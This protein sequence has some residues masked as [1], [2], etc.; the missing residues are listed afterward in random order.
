MEYQ[1]LERSV[2]TGEPNLLKIKGKQSQCTLYC[3]QQ[4]LACD[5]GNNLS[6]DG[7]N[8][9]CEVEQGYSCIKNGIEKTICTRIY[10]FS[11]QQAMSPICG[12]GII[13]RGEECD[14]QNLNS[15]DGCDNLCYVE[16]GFSMTINE[17]N[18]QII[19]KSCL[20]SGKLCLDLNEISGD[21]IFRLRLLKISCPK[22][23][24]SAQKTVIWLSKKNAMMET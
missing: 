4:S 15:N 17:K 16:E 24:K 5:D 11:E 22:N 2:I 1:S 7:C 20:K 19:Q 9:L 3:G 21:G 14:D 23:S 8:E 13:E 10:S 18:E 6:G 12:N